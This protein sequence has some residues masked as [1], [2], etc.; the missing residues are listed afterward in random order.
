MKLFRKQS[1][2]NLAQVYLTLIKLIKVYQRKT[3]EV[4]RGSVAPLS[5][6]YP[7]GKHIEAEFRTDIHHIEYDDTRHRRY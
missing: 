4:G 7:L 6:T 1:V 5:T 2:L 3:L